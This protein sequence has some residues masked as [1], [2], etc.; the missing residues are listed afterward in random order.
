MKRPRVFRQPG[1][2]AAALLLA[3]AAAVPAQEAEQAEDE[4]KKGPFKDF[5]ELTEDATVHQGFLDVYVKGDKTYMAIPPAR[6]DAPFIVTYEV[7]EGFG[8][9]GAAGGTM[10]NFE[11]DIVAF[12]RHGDRVFL[13]KR[14]HRFVAAAGTPQARAVDLTFSSSVLDV[15][16]IESIREDS[17]L[18]IEAQDWFLSDLSGISQRVRAAVPGRNGEPG[19]ASLNKERSFVEEVKSFPRNTTIRA[20]LT[21]TPGAPEPPELDEVPDPRFIPISIH[22]N[23]AALPDEPMTPRQADDRMGYFI[24]VVK[25][26]SDEDS[27]FFRR[28]VRK[29]RLEPGERVDD[30]YRP[31]KPIVYY[32]DH[33]VPER[34]REYFA[35]GIE[36][37]N[38]AFEEAGFVDAIRAEPLP[39]GADP[40]DIRYATLRWNTSNTPAYGAIGP[41]VVDPRTGEVLDAD[42]LFEAS[43][44]LAGRNIFRYTVDPVAVL[45]NALGLPA[46]GSPDVDGP[47]GRF[48]LTMD[49]ALS[50]AAGGWAALAARGEL[51]PGDPVPEEFLGEFLT[52]VVM[53]EVGHS[54]GLQHNFGSS[55]ATPLERLHDRSWAER[56]G[57]VASVM[58][59]HA[60]NVAPRGEKAGYYYTPSIGSYDRWMIAFGYTPDAERAATLARQGADPRHAFGADIDA[61]GPGALDPTVNVWDLSDDPLAWGRQRLAAI[62]STWMDLPE[63]VLVD[64]EPYLSLTNAYTALLGAMMSQA[65]APAIKYV[66][67]QYT[68]RD[69]VGDPDERPPFVSVPVQRQREAFRFVVNAVFAEDAFA[70]PQDVAAKFGANRWSPLLH[71]GNEVT[72]D[73]RIDFPFHEQMLAVQTAVLDQLTHPFRFSKIH[74]AELR[75]GEDEVLTIPE[76]MTA[77]SDAIWSELSASPARAITSSRRE[78]QRA[79]IARMTTILETPP[80]RT[81]ADARAMARYEL[82]R[83]KQATDR[84][85][86]DAQ[87]LDTYTQAH[88]QESSDRIGKVLEA[89]YGLE[90]R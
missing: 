43:F 49:A 21:F 18:V 50:Q 55:R 2:L 28:Y 68:H 31:V 22:Y 57:L 60:P 19:S 67:G 46:D 39:E 33:T 54:L 25:D 53:H 7:A 74:D 15:A 63:H 26:F 81:P 14:P 64:N 45:H 11:G 17:A 56:N 16:K 80:S 4:K 83:A 72:F 85:L 76:L 75:F 27:T 77:L 40:A 24:S 70:L 38:E 66:A 35:R 59:Y 23:L 48:P 10:L 86:Q 88:L 69:H 5:A 20:K 8:W 51:D 13:M 71:W 6:I 1:L 36:A 42:I 87:R 58:D 84:A 9:G 52:W 79:W 44:M 3:L 73:G 47:G 90:L 89:G 62:R 41:S 65:V 82:R 30:K 34:Y 61:G 37:W 32:I 29:W 12:E 78:L